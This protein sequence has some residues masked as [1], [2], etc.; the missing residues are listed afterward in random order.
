MPMTLDE[1][2]KQADDCRAFSSLAATEKIETLT[3]QELK[4]LYDN[5]DL[6]SKLENGVRSL[7]KQLNDMF[8][9]RQ[10][11]IEMALACF[12]SHLPMIALGPPGT[13]KSMVFRQIANGLGLSRK[14]IGIRD[15]QNEMNALLAELEAGA[16]KADVTVMPDRQYFEYLVTRYTTPDELLGPAN[17]DLMIK[18][19]LFYRQT[20]GLLPESQVAFLDEVF[21]ANSAILNALL[22]ILNERLY[23]NAGRA[24][25]VPLCMVFGASNEPPA[26]EELWALYD[27]FPVRVLCN[28]VEDSRDNLNLLLDKSMGHAFGNLI[29]GNGE[30][31]SRPSA[32]VNHFRLLHRMIH[33]K[34]K[35]WQ[36][37]ARDA[38]RKNFF[39]T[40]KALRREFQI[41]DRTM[42]LL[43][44]LCFALAMLREHGNPEP[45]ELDV[46]K[47]CFRD[48]EAAPALQDAVQERI[49]RYQYGN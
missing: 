16:G 42:F 48:P 2:R 28:P 7:Q 15:L 36:G 37:G 1:L 49:R 24:S 45:S 9:D 20:T 33:L 40:F 23:Y 31:Q 35:A 27:R 18:R 39:E 4:E 41:S 12:L 6:V 29:G 19:A 44:R 11:L 8:V 46:F 25:K 21:K 30:R 10:E 34:E 22:S 5:T 43:Y 38:F 26:E 17:L 13:A 47:Y 14:A 32:T 3:E